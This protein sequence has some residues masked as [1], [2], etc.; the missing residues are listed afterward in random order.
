[1][2]PHYIS[3]WET[4]KSL[5]KHYGYNPYKTVEF[6]L[7]KGGGNSTDFEY[8]GDIPEEEE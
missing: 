8:V 3:N 1:M 5:C 4:W 7:S 2:T 6:G